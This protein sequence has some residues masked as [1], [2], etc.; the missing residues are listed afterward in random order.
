LKGK[1]WEGRERDGRKGSGIEK[2]NGRAAPLPDVT[3][4]GWV[5]GKN[6]GERGKNLEGKGRV[7]GRT[8][9]RV[10]ARK[11][12]GRVKKKKG[13]ERPVRQVK[14]VITIKRCLD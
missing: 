12:G 3:D 2:K 13:R 9:R 8:R 11:I 4:Q 7:E 10:G 6:E 5:R 1:F 14:P